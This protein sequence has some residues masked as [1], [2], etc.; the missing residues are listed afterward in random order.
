VTYDLRHTIIPD[1]LTVGVGTVAFMH[2][3]LVFLGEGSVV[4]VL[5]DILAGMGAGLFFYLLWYYSKGRWIGLGDAKLATPL[6]V[7]AGTGGA[8]SM[9][10]LSFW[11]G[12]LVSVILLLL[13]YV[14]EK[15]K[16]V[17]P[18]LPKRL[19]MKSE[20][21]FAPFLVLGFLCALYLHANIFEITAAL[22]PFFL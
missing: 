4:R 3:V 22:F 5:Y 9:V 16:T 2:L 6:G 19:T 11:I 17:L 13:I 7:I 18:F 12:A 14:L 21:P 8:L 10:V 20:V 1:E 15:G